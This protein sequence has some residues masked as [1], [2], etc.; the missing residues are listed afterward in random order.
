MTQ[1]T[2][3]YHLN[4]YSRRKTLLK[5]KFKGDM[6]IRFDTNKAKLRIFEPIVSPLLR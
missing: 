5:K 2:F 1:P 6:M 3:I 4:H